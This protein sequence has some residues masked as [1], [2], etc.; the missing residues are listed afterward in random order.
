MPTEHSN[1]TIQAAAAAGHR[2]PTETSPP[3]ELTRQLRELMTSQL[4]MTAAHRR[5]AVALMIWSV[6]WSA[7][8]VWYEPSQPWLMALTCFISGATGGMMLLSWREAGRH[9]ADV[10][11]D[12]KKLDEEERS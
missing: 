3:P 4:R 12:L 5:R 9:A 1:G 2:A 10:R 8:W 11:R 7:F 6:G